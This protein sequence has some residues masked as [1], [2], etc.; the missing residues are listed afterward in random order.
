MRKIIFCFV[1]ILSLLQPKSIQ[2]QSRVGIYIGG[3]ATWYYGD[4]ND[5]LLTNNKLFRT[6][7]NGGLLYRLHPHLD[8]LAN[9]TFGKIVG[10]DSLAIQ[11]FNRKR[12]LN[13]ESKIVE[14]SLLFNY[15]LLENTKS[16]RRKFN[17]YII[18]GVGYLKLIKST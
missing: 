3:G 10:A 15:R 1:I 6:Y 9:V 12:N 11:L 4:M 8:I 2:A 18:A 16:V 7:F 5:R 17:P 14:A 13:F